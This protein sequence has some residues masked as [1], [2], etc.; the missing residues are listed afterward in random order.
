MKKINMVMGALFSLVAVAGT[1]NAAESVSGTIQF[2][3]AISAESCYV[4]SAIGDANSVLV[5]LGTVN[6]ASVGSVSAPNFV[7]GAGL[8]LADFNVV[9]KNEAKV[10][11]ALNAPQSEVDATG[12][13]LRVNN[14][15]TNAGYAQNVGIAVYPSSSSSDAYSLTSQKLLDAVTVAAGTS[16]NVKFNA[17]YVTRGAGQPT[18]GQANAT[19]PFVLEIQ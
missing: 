4:E 10:S 6:T 13:V 14:G 2:K 5:N 8:S 11:M 17:A 9:C 16:A 12:K 15:V 3:G 18:A 7:T 19:L 1:A